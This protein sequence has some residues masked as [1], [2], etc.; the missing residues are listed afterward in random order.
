MAL[1]AK[2]EGE[3]KSAMLAKDKDRLRA[4]RSIKSL[5]M[6]AETEK[7]VVAELTEDAEM[8]ILVKAAKQRKDSLDVFEKQGRQ[9]LADVERQELGVIEEFLP[10]QMSED[11]MRVELEAI[12]KD[13]G[14]SSMKEMGKVMGIASKKLAGRVDNKKM[15]EIIKSLLS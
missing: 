9:D 4:L 8:A 2:I 12:V 15:S 10:K 1:K 5:I 13:L 7:G 3:I 14:V 11:E 6:L